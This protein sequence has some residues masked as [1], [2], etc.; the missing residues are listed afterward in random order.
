[1]SR[2]QYVL[3]GSLNPA[4]TEAGILLGADPMA[5]TGT[6]TSAGIL[7]TIGDKQEVIINEEETKLTNM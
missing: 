3:T 7:F 4:S 6:M 5:P 2:P 1:M